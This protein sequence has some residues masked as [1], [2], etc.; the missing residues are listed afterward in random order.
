MKLK[1]TAAFAAYSLVVVGLFAV[2]IL[3]NGPSIPSGGTPTLSEKAQSTRAPV[4]QGRDAI[5]TC[6]LDGGNTWYFSIGRTVFRLTSQEYPSTI[7]QFQDFKRVDDIDKRYDL[8]P[9]NPAS[10]IG[11]EENPQQLSD[12]DSIGLQLEQNDYLG[13]MP[14]HAAAI[15]MFFNSSVDNTPSIN[16]ALFFLHGEYNFCKNQ[17]ALKIFKDGTFLCSYRAGKLS[18]SSKDVQ[19]DI[20]HDW[21][22]IISGNLYLTPMGSNLTMIELSGFANVSYLF[23]QDI[24]LRY[25]INLP[26]VASQIDQNYIINV[27]RLV[28]AKIDSHIVENYPWPEQTTGESSNGAQ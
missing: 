1:S 6:K 7:I 21:E 13:N 11:C 4:Q 28:R 22:F 9:P 17:K 18:P 23:S 16:P 14:K 20:I 12:F 27:D 25:T 26:V 8:M 19:N 5:Q 2:L 24:F 15:E 10:P 3:W